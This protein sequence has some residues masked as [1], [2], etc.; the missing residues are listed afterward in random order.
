MKYENQVDMAESN[1]ILSERSGY[2]WRMQL[3]DFFSENKKQL[4]DRNVSNM[5][6]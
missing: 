5:Q 3:S 6:I 2:K 1:T 4:T